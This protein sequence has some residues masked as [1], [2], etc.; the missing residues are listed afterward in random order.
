MS[1][2]NNFNQSFLSKHADKFAI[3]CVILGT[4]SLLWGSNFIEPIKASTLSTYLF[5]LAGLFG[6]ADIFRNRNIKI[7]G[8]IAHDH[9]GKIEVEILK[10][11]E[12]GPRDKHTGST[13]DP[14]PGNRQKAV[15][16]FWVKCEEHTHQSQY[17]PVIESD[18]DTP[19]PSNVQID[20]QVIFETN[21]Q[22]VVVSL[23]FL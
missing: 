17:Y 4:I 13:V 6:A 5:A 14:P 7:T 20:E 21:D 2:E 12:S 15:I 3:G 8:S 1:D 19:L 22:N 16:A 10:R 23:E 9:N 11:T 18:L